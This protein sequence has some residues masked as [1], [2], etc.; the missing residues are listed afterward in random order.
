MNTR[1]TA[2]GYHRYPA[3]VLAIFVLVVVAA[4]VPGV[5]AQEN[6]QR[7]YSLRSPEYEALRSLYIEVG[8][9]L[10]FSSGPFSE[11]EI[12]SALARLDDEV[13]SDAAADTRGWLLQQLTPPVLYSEEQGRFRIN[14]SAQFSVESYLHTDQ[15]NPYWEYRWED[16]QPF[17]RFPIETWVG[18]NAYGIVDLAFMKNIPD[19]SIYPTYDRSGEIDFETTEEDPWSN[20]P[21]DPATMDTQYPHRAFLSVGGDRWNASVGRDQID[22]G[23]G[24][25]G[26]LYISDYAEWYDSAQFSTFW[27]RFKFSWMWVSLDGTITAEEREY[28]E[29]LV[30]WDTDADGAVDTYVDPG[31]GT[32]VYSYDPDEEHKNL[33]AHR[34]ELRLWERLGFAYTMGIVYG[35]EAV[36]LRHLNPLYNYHNLYTNTQN[37]GNAHRSYELD[38]AVT[39]GISVYGVFSPDQWT[40][41]LEPETDITS[42][43]NAWAALLGIDMRRPLGSG[44]LY[45]TL[46]GVY[47]TPWMYIHNHPLT[48]LTSRRYVLA[49]HGVGRTQVYYDKPLGHY[50]GN[51]FALLWFDLAR[52]TPGHYRYGLNLAWEGDGSVPINALLESKVSDDLREPLDEDDAT[53][54]APSSGYDG[55]EAMWKGVVSVYGEIHPTGFGRFNEPGGRRRLRLASELSAQWTKNRY[56]EQGEWLFD[57]QWIVSTTFTF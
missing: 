23:N 28:S 56:H 21:I 57:L 24:R 52:G 29:Y 4:V 46:E 39:P 20:W 10:P 7:V 11:A 9:A 48:S 8:R 15:D 40:S 26:N 43:P 49:H 13:L 37:T 51:D 17:A 18:S 38:F 30:G 55:R 12:R 19:F 54:V 3:F 41:P 5:W 33:I 14:G 44:Y 22:W 6:S 47:A 16:R 34:F 50:G 53:L 2:I 1:S 35:R 45:G 25:T 36:E 32:P 27:D 42:E 31:T